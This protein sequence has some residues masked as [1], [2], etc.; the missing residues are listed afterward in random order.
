MQKLYLV[1]FTTDLK[2]LIFARRRGAKS[3]SFLVDV[4]GRLRRALEEVASLEAEEKKKKPKPAGERAA[5]PARPSRLSPR[6]IQELLRKGKSPQEVAKLAET[7]VAWVERF[8]NPILAERAGVVDVVKAGSISKQRLGESSL[9]IGEAI[10][11]NLRDRKISIPPEILD[12]GWNAIRRNNHWE[13]TFRYLSRGQR[14]VATFSFDPQIRA[15][16]AVDEVARDIGWRPSAEPQ[17]RR[18][19]RKRRRRNR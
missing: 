13:I 5:A 7:D 2:N 16:T 19:P 3:G 6:E 18:T 15:V 17:A 8:T 11:A 9:P 10:I 1:G 14:K 12:E 4:D